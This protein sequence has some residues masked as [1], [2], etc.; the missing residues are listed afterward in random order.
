MSDDGG[1]RVSS[2]TRFR[3]RARVRHCRTIDVSDYCNVRLL[4]QHIRLFC[5]TI[6]TSD[7][8]CWTIETSIFVGLL[9]RRTT[10]AQQVKK[11]SSS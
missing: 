10:G 9:R 4:P 8:F 1:V 3:V 7:N 5:R 6:E 2:R 11:T